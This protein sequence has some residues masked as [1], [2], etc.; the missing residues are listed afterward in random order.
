MNGIVPKDAAFSS[1]VAGN[2]TA[3]NITAES[4]KF[5]TVVVDVFGI[6]PGGILDMGGGE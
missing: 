2:L 1:I 3:R 6:S 5:G 4:G